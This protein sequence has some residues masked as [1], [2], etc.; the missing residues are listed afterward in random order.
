MD[1]AKNEDKEGFPLSA[2]GSSN[3]ADKDCKTQMRFALGYHRGL[4]LLREGAQF[5]EW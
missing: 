2:A 5:Q 4:I 3:D 1:A